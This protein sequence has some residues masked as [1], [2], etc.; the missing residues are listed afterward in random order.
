MNYKSCLLC[1][2]VWYDGSKEYN[3]ERNFNGC[4]RRKSHF[5]GA[6]EIIS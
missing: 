6:E 4:E 5:E 3:I 2:K 1:K